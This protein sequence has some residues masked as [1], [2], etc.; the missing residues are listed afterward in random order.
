MLLAIGALATDQGAAAGGR[1]AEGHRS[2]EGEGQP[3]RVRGA[4]GGGN[5]AVFVTANGVT[6]VDAKNP[7]G[8]SRSSTRSRS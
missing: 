2:R 6:V 5:T 3:V 4:N 8:A 7:A 1:R